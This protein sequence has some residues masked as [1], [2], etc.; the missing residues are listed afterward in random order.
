MTTTR[1]VVYDEVAKCLK[2]QQLDWTEPMWH[3]SQMTILMAFAELGDSK[4]EVAFDMVELVKCYGTRSTHKLVDA[5]CMN[6]TYE[7]MDEY[8]E[9]MTHVEPPKLL[10]SREQ[11]LVDL[12]FEFAIKSP[13]FTWAGYEEHTMNCT[14]ANWVQSTLKDC[15][16]DTTPCG[17]SWGVLKDG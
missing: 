11:K 15:G 13:G 5:R 14:I 8:V 7:M 4:T 6:A 9:K 17:M 10:Q 1:D 16:F 3:R 2:D 12:C